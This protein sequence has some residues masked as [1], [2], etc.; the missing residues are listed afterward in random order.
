MSSVAS[1]LTLVALGLVVLAACAPAPSPAGG[2]PAAGSSAQSGAPKT[3]T[4]ALQRELAAFGDFTGAGGT[5]GNAPEVR[6]IAHDTLVV[7][8]GQGVYVPQL[9][10]EQLSVDRGTWRL[11]ADGSMD[12]TWR[13]HP[14][15]KWHDGTPFTS[16]DLLFSFALYKDTE[17]PTEYTSQ[18]ALMQSASAPD[19]FTLEIHWSR[20]YTK[21]DR[22]P[23]LDPLPRHLLEELYRQDRASFINSPIFTTEW[24][25]LGPYKLARWEAGSLMEFVRFDDYYRGRPPLDRVLVQYIRDSNAMLA[26]FLAG[27]VDVVPPPNLDVETAAEVARRLEGSGHRVRM[28]PT[29]RFEQLEFQMRPEAARPRNGVTNRAVRQALYHATDRS[30]LA[31]VLNHN[32][33]PVTDH[34]YP[35]GHPL[36]PDVDPYAPRYAYDLGRAQQLLAEAGWTRA[37]DAVLT[38]PDGERFQTEVWARAGVAGLE[39]AIQVVA[40]Q[41]RA[42][43]IQAT[44]YTIP[45]ALSA[46]REYE[47]KYP[48]VLG[49][50]PNAEEMYESRLLSRQTS[51]PENRWTGRNRAGYSNPRV[52]QLIDELA[53]AVDPRQQVRIH[54]DLVGEVFTDLPFIPV[55]WDVYP[56]LVLGSVKGDPSAVNAGW[57]I[58]EWDK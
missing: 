40:D 10:E 46:D 19:P 56:V 18:A 22:A 26:N 48:G 41:W 3:L 2:G 53:V 34:W 7:P 36:I 6:H 15:A 20:V 14:N 28:D 42:A 24:V 27:S 23:A 11:N 50:F 21:A 37:S 8:N 47:A 9:A 35:P 4:I 52:D 12:T 54:R 1:A 29:T 16:A 13:I 43:G 17:M 45:P 49:G 57:N 5:G 25:G 31:E 44:P 55:T 51:G 32:L 33:A 38:S 30:A 58:F 39:K